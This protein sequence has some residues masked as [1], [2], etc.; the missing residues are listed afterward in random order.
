MKHNIFAVLTDEELLNILCQMT[1]DSISH[2]VRGYISD[3]LER[4]RRILSNVPISNGTGKILEVGAI[5]NTLPVYLNILQYGFV[6][7]QNMWEN[8]LLNE[9]Y[10]KSSIDS[11]KIQ[12][13]YFD[14]E[15]A[16]FPYEDNQFD[17]VICSEVLEHLSRDPMHMMVE[18][19]R[20]LK[21]GGLFILTTPNI[22][23]FF[24]LYRFLNGK[25]PYMWSS[26]DGHTTDRHNRE[27]TIDEIERLFYD[28]GFNIL[29][30]ETFSRKPVPLK[31]RLVALWTSLPW[32]MRG[33]KHLQFKNMG[34]FIFAVGAKESFFKERFPKWLYSKKE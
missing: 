33:K 10:I 26:Y 12:I 28:A 11:P 23:S 13:D 14:I 32:L 2:E 22:S 1:P 29:K 4:F 9:Q 5:A 30:L 34:E 15:V 21:K 3:H 25:H 7:M 18:I 6:A 8:D 31:F 20:V 24:S 17:V 19:S 27:Y 16:P